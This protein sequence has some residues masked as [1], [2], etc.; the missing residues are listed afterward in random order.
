MD[1]IKPIKKSKQRET[2]ICEKQI[3]LSCDSSKLCFCPTKQVPSD[4]NKLALPFGQGWLPPKSEAHDVARLFHN[5]S[6]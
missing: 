4:K 3:L 2:A 6:I 5:L 1:T